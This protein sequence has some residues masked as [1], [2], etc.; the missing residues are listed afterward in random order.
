[1]TARAIEFHPV[2]ELA[3][4]VV[5]VLNGLREDLEQLVPG[6]DA[7]WERSDDGTTWHPWMDIHFTRADDTSGSRLA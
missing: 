2:A 6:I 4:A 3:S 1:V 5:S 7:L